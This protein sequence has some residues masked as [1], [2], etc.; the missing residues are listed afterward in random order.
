MD[1]ANLD[2]VLFVPS[3]RPPHRGAAVAE[4]DAR[5]AMTGLAIRGQNGFD[6]SDVEIKRGGASYTADTMIELKRRYPQDEL[7]LILG[8]DAARLFSTWRRPEEIR[9]LASFVV[10]SRPGAPPPDAAQL[11]EAGLDPARVVL[12]LRPTPDISGSALRRAIAH[13]ES[14][15][16]LL[17]PSVDAY[18]AEHRL[19]RDNRQV[20][21]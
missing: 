19:Y 2:R 21:G 12:C 3:A 10:V 18:I 5:L 11:K 15:A 17:P 4:A 20:G 7:F 8:W 1:C 9:R 16:N 14:V 13:G 6:L